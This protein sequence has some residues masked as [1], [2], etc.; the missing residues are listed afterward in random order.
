MMFELIKKWEGCKLK[1]YPDPAT[2]GEPYTIGYGTTFYP[3]G[4]KVKEGDTCTKEEADGLLLWYCTTKIK[5]P[6]GTFTQNQKEALYSLLYN[7]NCVAFHKS[8][9]CRAIENQDWEVAFKEW[10]WDKAG[11]KVL[12]GLINRRREE[13]ALFFDGLLDVESLEKKYYS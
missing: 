7:I 6:K 5:L 8:K 3:D 9:C 11:G 1:A 10:N 12:K 2:G 13:R 4:S